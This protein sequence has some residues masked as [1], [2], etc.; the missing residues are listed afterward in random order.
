VEHQ[1]TIDLILD[2][3]ENP[4]HYG[5]LPDA[6]VVMRGINPGC[7]D[8]IAIYAKADDAG[9]ISAISFEG[10]GCTISM[11]GASMATE[12]LWGKALAEVEATPEAAILELF[13]REIAATRFR[14]ALLG[15]NTA[16]DAARA[17]RSRQS[18]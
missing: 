9:H 3:Y 7:G 14:C 2:H 6:D 5:A 18:G 15:L 4:R 13:G 10:E 16:K 11:A 1:T 8:V 17:L 12:I